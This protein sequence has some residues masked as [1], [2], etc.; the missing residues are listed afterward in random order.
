MLNRLMLGVVVAFL[1]APALYAGS[2]PVQAT[3]HMPWEGFSKAAAAA[4]CQHLGFC[5]VAIP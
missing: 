2:V 5:F 4:I 3:S 1:V